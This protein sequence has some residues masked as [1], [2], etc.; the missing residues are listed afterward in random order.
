MRQIKKIFLVGIGTLAIVVDVMHGMNK[1][2]ERVS[3]SISKMLPK[4]L[5]SQCVLET[6]EDKLAAA[7]YMQ[8]AAKVADIFRIGVCKERKKEY[9][10]ALIQKTLIGG[11]SPEVLQVLID[12]KVD[13]FYVD[14]LTENTIFHDLI[15]A[16][17]ENSK[18]TLDAIEKI[19]ELMHK[20]ANVDTYTKKLAPIYNEDEE[21]ALTIACIKPAFAQLFLQYLSYYFTKKELADFI[22]KPNEHDNNTFLHEV[23]NNLDLDPQTKMNGIKILLERGADV[24]VEGVY[25]FDVL[26]NAVVNGSIEVVLMLLCAYPFSH[27]YIHTIASDEDIEDI[28]PERQQ[29]LRNYK[30][31]L[32][33][34]PD[35][36]IRKELK[37]R[38]GTPNIS[39]ALRNR[40][41][42]SKIVRKKSNNAQI[43][44]AQKKRKY[45]PELPAYHP[46]QMAKAYR[47]RPNFKFN[48]IEQHSAPYEHRIDIGLD[49][50]A[51]SF[52]FDDLLHKEDF[53]SFGPSS[54][55]EAMEYKE[56]TNKK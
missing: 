2:P 46:Q 14:P 26:S 42:G 22:N 19:F 16:Y 53:T 47:E 20:Q 29:I 32:V 24:Y 48:H 27:K 30:S 43:C 9:E 31:N 1:N 28:V 35:S 50:I 11:G 36:C 12:N 10:V 45:G 6:Y 33:T 38:Y 4:D 21:T 44:G 18:I 39:A 8:D 15:I 7:C 13:I 51:E 49:T 54:F 56:D 41:I 37:R 52:A 34:H 25:G 17:R 40:E 3:G 5:A 55:D 23:L